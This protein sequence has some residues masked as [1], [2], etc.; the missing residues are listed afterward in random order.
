MKS[1]TRA[2]KQGHRPRTTSGSVLKPRE[3]LLRDSIRCQVSYE[4]YVLMSKEET[5]EEAIR[6][7]TSL[8]KKPDVVR[9]AI[10]NRRHFINRKIEDGLV[11]FQVLDPRS[12]IINDIAE[13]AQT[14]TINVVH[15]LE[16][17]YKKIC[18]QINAKMEIQQTA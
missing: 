2:P 10:Y 17:H 16:T 1:T 6:L 8:E 9:K 4:P 14:I 13:K 11:K 18:A 7:A 12:P 15:F 3:E 5:W